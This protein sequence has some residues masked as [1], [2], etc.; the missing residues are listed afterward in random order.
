MSGLD[1]DL[2][3]VSAAAGAASTPI[4]PAGSTS[5]S[6]GE[7]SQLEAAQP[8]QSHRYSRRWASW[9]HGTAAADDDATKASEANPA[10]PA[11]QIRPTSATT[12]LPAPPLAE[13]GVA[14]PRGRGRR[15]S[16]MRGSARG[17]GGLSPGHT[18]PLRAARPENG[19]T[20]ESFDPLPQI[21]Q[22]VWRDGGDDS[23]LSDI[24]AAVHYSR[25]TYSQTVQCVC[26]RLSIDNSKKVAGVFAVSKAG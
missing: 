9:R 8:P 13:R 20:A 25:V 16:R 26:C 24:P 21:G 5:S 15:P 3:P 6:E 4:R 22:G 2:E 10:A 12:D 11:D 7:P 1:R 18:R 14:S 19:A 17:P 23:D